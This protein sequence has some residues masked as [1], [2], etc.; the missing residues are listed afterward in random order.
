MCLAIVSNLFHEPYPGSVAH[1]RMSLLLLD[2]VPLA[3]WVAFYTI[4]LLG[5]VANTVAAMKMWPGSQEANQTVRRDAV[6]VKTVC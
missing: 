6:I 4:D 1:N 5:P 3:N 2:D